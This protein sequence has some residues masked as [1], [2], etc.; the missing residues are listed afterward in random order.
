MN[1]EDK[2]KIFA[3]N[4]R[5]AR[6][7][8]GLSKPAAA[9]KLNIQ[10]AQYYRY[11]AGRAE[12]GMFMVTDIASKLQIPVS[13]LLE[14]IE[15]DTLKNEFIVNRLRSY[16]IPAEVIV[17]DNEHIMVQINNFRPSKEPVNF[18]EEVLSIADEIAKDAMKKAVPVAYFKLLFDTINKE[19]ID[20]QLTEAFK[21][22]KTPN[23]Q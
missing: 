7:S 18:M 3:E 10:P 6:E 4:L 14:G 5:K 21:K 11:E 16:G 20:N 8:A 22:L 2:L 1:K 15:E 13:M 19:E 12:P 23:N 17:G 9:E